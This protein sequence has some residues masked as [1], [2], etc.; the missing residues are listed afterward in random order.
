MVWQEELQVGRRLHNTWHRPVNISV[1]IRRAL[2]RGWIGRRD[3]QSSLMY[4]LP[5]V[6]QD[7]VV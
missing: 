2:G 4:L 5:A 3:P 1:N 7:Y 6:P